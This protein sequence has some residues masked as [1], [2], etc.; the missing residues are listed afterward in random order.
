MMIKK[1][2]SRACP[3]KLK[4]SG[5]F[6]LLELVLAIAI[7]S[8]SSFAIANM[9]IDANISTRLNTEKIA[10]LFY[11]KG[12][13]E[14]VR[15]IRDNNLATFF[16]Y[17]P[18]DYYLSNSNNTWALTLGGEPEILDSKYTRTVNIAN[19]LDVA[20]ATSK[21]VSVNV[22]W[23]LTPAR[24]ASTTLTTILTSWK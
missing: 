4:R 18:G 17:T 6:S 16:T 23:A 21:T 12:G 22:S 3:A 10:A 14:A 8:L 11:T 13:I 20:A 2:K 15:I 7:F 9:L 24:P 19:T 5:G 1:N